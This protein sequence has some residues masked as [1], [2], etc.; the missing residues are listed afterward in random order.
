MTGLRAR[1]GVIAS[2]AFPGLDEAI[3]NRRRDRLLRQL[4]HE[5]RYAQRL[6]DLTGPSPDSSAARPTHL[7]VVPDEGPETA[8]WTAGG[9]NFFYEIAQAAREYYGIDRVSIYGIDG[10]RPSADWHEDLIRHLVVSGATHV[11]V[12]A[13]A[14]PNTAKAH[15]SWD[16]LWSQLYPRWDGVLLGLVTDSYFTWITAAAR[17]LARMCDRFVLVDICMPMD[18]VLVPGRPEVGPVNMPVSNESLAVIDAACA[19]TERIYDVSF[20]GTLYP[21][22]VELLDAIRAHGATVAV[23]PHREVPATDYA[24]SRAHVPSYVDYMKALAQSR[25]TIN[26]SQTNAGTEQQLKTRIL[27]AAAMGCLVLTDDV[28]RTD[29]FW[30]PEAE[31]GFFPD[32]AS[33]PAVV[34]SWLADPE[35]LER[36]RLAGQARARA[37]NDSSF[38]GGVEEG[39]RRRGLPSIGFP[40][41][42]S[43]TNR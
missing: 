39:L 4:V 41:G 12:Q 16:V 11:M 38:W 9:G 6:A 7:V 42:F 28:D 30:V 31:Y 21:Y 25:I 1:L 17:R 36:A 3:F 20:I 34:E 18:G 29:R 37:I 19:D 40:I 24:S 14:D 2:K 8:S 27:E 32:P 10:N 26:F 22:R 5:G 13:E 35:R 15:Y 43:V 33:L 23:N